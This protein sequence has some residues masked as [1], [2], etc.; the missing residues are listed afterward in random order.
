VCTWIRFDF[1]EY[2]LPYDGA[3]MYVSS[4]G[5]YS[6]SVSHP[7]YKVQTLHGLPQSMQ[8][9]LFMHTQVVITVRTFGKKIFLE[10]GAFQWP[11]VWIQ[12]TYLWTTKLFAARTACNTDHNQSYWFHFFYHNGKVD[13]CYVCAIWLWQ[14][15]VKSSC[16]VKLF[17]ISVFRIF[18]FL[19][20]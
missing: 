16:W 1:V 12:L 13:I 8:P 18:V 17:S 3:C 4:G 19:I 15:T 20:N 11:K 14:N 2:F 10:Q 5:Q 9:C 6:E 7:G